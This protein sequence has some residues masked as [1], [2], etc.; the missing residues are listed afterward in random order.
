[1]SREGARTDPDSLFLELGTGV[2]YH[3][4]QKMEP[5]TNEAPGR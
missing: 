4:T 5:A 3:S 1:L 2:T